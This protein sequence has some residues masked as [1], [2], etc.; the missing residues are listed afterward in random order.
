[1]WG[2]ETVPHIQWL[3]RH[4]SPNHATDFFHERGILSRQA[5]A[6]AIAL[7]ALAEPSPGEG[8]QQF[9]RR[10]GN[11]EGLRCLG[12][13]QAPE[14]A[15][16][17]LIRCFARLRLS[18]DHPDSASNV[19][20]GAGQGGGVLGPVLLPRKPLWSLS[21]YPQRADNTLSE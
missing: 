16:M 15:G 3:M 12:G 19:S 9:V 11:I 18:G 21:D 10:Q 4:F 6:P 2:V 7:D 5:V 1:M 20:S 17:D 14:L 8:P 13:G